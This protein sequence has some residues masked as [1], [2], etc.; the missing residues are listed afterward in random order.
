M[1]E[2]FAREARAAARIRGRDA[3]RV[4]DV[5]ELPDGAPY[6]VVDCLD[7]YLWFEVGSVASDCILVDD[8]RLTRTK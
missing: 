2:R 8:V 5:G 1:V 7:A 3:A 6:M 4:V